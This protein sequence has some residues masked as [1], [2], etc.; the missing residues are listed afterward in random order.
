ME[1]LIYLLWSPEGREPDATRKLLLDEVAPA[2]LKQ[3]VRGHDAAEQNASSVRLPTLAR[4]DLTK[5]TQE[6]FLTWLVRW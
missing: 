5:K 1:K 4:P 6:L 2:L 3:G